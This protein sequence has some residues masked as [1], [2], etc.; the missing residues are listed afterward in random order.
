[1]IEEGWLRV[2]VILT[3]IPFHAA[4]TYLR[5]GNVYIKASVTGLSA[6]P[7]VIATVPLGD[8]F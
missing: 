6:L 1:M 5:F 2:L 4:L 8:F 7:F 3:L